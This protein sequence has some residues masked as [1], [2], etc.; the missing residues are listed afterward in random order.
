MALV[1]YKKC[2]K[3]RI[4]IILNFLVSISTFFPFNLFY[5]YDYFWYYFLHI[6]FL[7]ACNRNRTLQ[8]FCA[9]TVSIM[10]YSRDN[11]IFHISLWRW[12]KPTYTARKT[13]FPK[14]WNIMESSKRPSKYHLSINFLAEKKD[15]ISHTEKCK[16]TTFQ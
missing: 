14:P 16:A 4:C 2:Y 10:F 3:N 12:S 8:L 6:F 5:L 11:N 9:I 15:H 7:S 1:R 13:I